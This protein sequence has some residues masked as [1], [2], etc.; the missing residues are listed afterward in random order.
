MA[1]AKDIVQDPKRAEVIDRLQGSFQR[2]YDL[3]KP[4]DRQTLVEGLA[5]CGKA[6][7]LSGQTAGLSITFGT[8]GITGVTVT[9]TPTPVGEIKKDQ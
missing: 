3:S 6:V 9:A 7:A 4:A 8:D 2:D 5:E 1:N